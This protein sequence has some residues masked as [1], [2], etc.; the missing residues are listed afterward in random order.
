MKIKVLASVG[1]IKK[2]SGVEGAK[3]LFRIGRPY[4][5]L[6]TGTGNL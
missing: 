1:S 3:Y 4:G 6:I 5:F 2:V